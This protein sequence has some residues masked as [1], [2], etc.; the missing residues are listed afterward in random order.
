MILPRISN[1]TPLKI[2]ISSLLLPLS[3]LILLFFLR[4]DRQIQYFL[5]LLLILLIFWVGGLIIGVFL[6]AINPDPSKVPKFFFWSQISI[7]SIILFYIIYTEVPEM[8]R[9]FWHG[10]Q[11][12]NHVVVGIDSSYP[13]HGWKSDGLKNAFFA[14]ESAQKKP[15]SFRIGY[16]FSESF[17]STF[18][19]I[20]NSYS[21][22]Y[23][24]YKK[25]NEV[26]VSK[27]RIENEIHPEIIYFDEKPLLN[28]DFLRA[29]KSIKK[30]EKEVI[31]ELKLSL[32]GLSDSIK[33]LW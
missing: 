29:Y 26:L 5:G 11:I 2:I 18:D 3:L 14:L 31:N 19:S 28:K 27:V 10:N 24:L 13:E 17:D 32:E 12:H 16:Y 20:K 25:K 21:D 30:E 23:F 7:F 1:A 4:S 9:N 15:N 8:W 33:I 22:I 6:S